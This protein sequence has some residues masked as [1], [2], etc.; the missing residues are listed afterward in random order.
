MDVPEVVMRDV[1]PKTPKKEPHQ[2]HG[3]DSYHVY[4]GYLHNS[5]RDEKIYQQL[6][7]QFSNSGVTS[8]TDDS[9]V[10]RCDN[11]MEGIKHSRK[12]SFIY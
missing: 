1:R 6:W 8:Y 5:D 4:I 9:V 12:V 3:P 11:I 7:K 2:L 10:A